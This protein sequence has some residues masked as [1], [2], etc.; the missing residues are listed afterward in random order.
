MKKYLSLL[1]VLLFVVFL[2][3]CTSGKKLYVL[4][5][6]DYIDQTLID[7]FEEEYDCKVIYTEVNSNEEIYQKL[8][9]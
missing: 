3:S 4:N 6:G 5:V 1:F 7:D 9:N 2:V 8:K